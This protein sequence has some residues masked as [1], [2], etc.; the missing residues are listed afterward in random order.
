MKLLEPVRKSFSESNNGI[1][2]SHLK[3]LFPDT[4][5]QTREKVFYRRNGKTVDKVVEFDV[6]TG[7]KLR[8]THYDYFD[9]KKIR[10]VDEYDKQTGRKLRTINYVL[11]KSI[12]EYDQK[13]GKKIRTIN[14][15]VKDE[16]KISSIQEYDIN[17]GK[18]VKV[19]IYKR[20]GRSVSIIKN[21]DPVTNEVK[22]TFN[23]TIENNP[24]NNFKY[25]RSYDNY[26]SF[27]TEL[28]ENAKEDIAKLI[29]NLY[30][31]NSMFESLK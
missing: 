12:D 10:S 30:K 13:T 15:N 2:D 27:K 6:K 3:L 5:D 11:Y 28:K 1:E 19:S 24:S 25:T 26:K 16:A 22:N 29:D 4:K 23:K 21:I 20:D 18:I 14:F 7:S 31:N 8:I 17:T 9:D